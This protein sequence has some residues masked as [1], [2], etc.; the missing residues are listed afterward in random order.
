MVV[1]WMI[2][3]N[4][5]LNRTSGSRDGVEKMN[6]EDLLDVE[7]P[8]LGNKLILGAVRREGSDISSKL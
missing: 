6:V 1:Q 8:G 7:P 3:E 4:G 5:G 2:K